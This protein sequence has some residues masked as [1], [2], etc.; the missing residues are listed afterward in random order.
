MANYTL[1][2][3][4]DSQGW[5]SFYSFYPEFIRGMNAYLYTFKGGNLYRHNS[6][7]VSRNNFYGIQ[8]ISTVTGVLN[9]KPLEIKL[10]KTISY[11][12]NTN[13]GLYA[14]TEAR[15]AVESLNTDLIAFPNTDPTTPTI[16]EDNFVEKEGEWYSYIRSDA[17]TVNWKLRSAH[18][19]APA[20]T[21]TGGG[22]ATMIIT[23]A[24]P[25][26]YII[27]VG[28]MAYRLNGAVTD[29]LGLVTAISNVVGDYSI[30]INNVNAAPPPT[31]PTPVPGE[32]I[33]YY[34]NSVAESFGARGYYLEFKL[35]NNSLRPVELFA[36]SG[37]VMK[38]FP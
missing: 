12:A 26:G 8:G 5:P 25:P 11:E 9:D 10:Y 36:V 16:P 29:A 13:I 6:S 17:S 4:P 34:K 15:W 38:S 19:L 1:T 14:S 32:L 7:T 21:V 37:S 2:Y 24:T 23:F 35:S 30:T 3:N 28:D 22:T 18:G 20:V 33:L 31:Y 27:S